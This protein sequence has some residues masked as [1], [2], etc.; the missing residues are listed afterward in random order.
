MLRSNLSHEQYEAILKKSK[1]ILLENSSYDKLL[2]GD[3]RKQITQ[4]FTLTFQ[5]KE[6]KIYER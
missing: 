4:Q 1:T 3:I 5:N 6:S 2:P